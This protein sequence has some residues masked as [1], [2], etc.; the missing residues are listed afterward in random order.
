VA[1]LPVEVTVL[2]EAALAD[3][4]YGGILGVGQ[5]SSAP[6]RL[7]ELTYAPDGATRHDAHVG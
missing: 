6:P 7:V 3:G 4:G 1:D 5:G 2:D